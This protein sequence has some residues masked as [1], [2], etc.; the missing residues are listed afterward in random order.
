MS[1]PSLPVYFVLLLVAGDPEKLS[2]CDLRVIIVK[3]RVNSVLVALLSE[4]IKV[5]TPEL[6]ERGPVTKP[7]IR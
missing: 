2:E 3:V 4:G 6:A 5:S 7:D 1:P